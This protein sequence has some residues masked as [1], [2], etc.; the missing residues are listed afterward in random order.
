[1]KRFFALLI[2]LVTLCS[3]GQHMDLDERTMV[4]KHVVNSGHY[5]LSK[6]TVE[7]KNASVY[8]TIMFTAPSGL[9]NVGDTLTFKK[10]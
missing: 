3:C 2:S 9:Y 6:Y 5:D 1:M 10:K 4:V 8:R 7:V